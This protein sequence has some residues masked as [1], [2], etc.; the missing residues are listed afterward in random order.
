V[1]DEFRRRLLARAERAALRLNDRE[2]NQIAAYYRLLTKW[3]RAINLTAAKLSPLDDPSLDRLLIEPLKAAE[4]IVD[5]PIDWFDVGSGGGSP[6]IPIKI[7]RPSSRL[8]MIEARSRKSAFLRTAVRELQLVDVQ[9][10]QDR[11][12][13]VAE[14]AADLI[15]VRAVRI[16]ADLLDTAA[17]LCRHMGRM[18]VFTSETM[19]DHPNFNLDR[20]VELLP[21]GRSHVLAFRCM[22][23]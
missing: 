5:E 12:E 7:V 17:R 8:T 14:G 20:A 21:H 22:K 3:N 15:T 1:S 6:A 4:L 10:I 18:L 11:F 23:R 13:D 9:I 19:L 16:D 2:V